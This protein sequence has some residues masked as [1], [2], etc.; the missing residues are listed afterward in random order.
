M[1]AI[2]G[3]ALLCGCTAL[4]PLPSV[5][6]VQ[7]PPV[8]PGMA[9]AWYYRA[10]LPYNGT[11]R[12]YVQMNGANVGIAELGGAFYR[13][14]APGPYY[15]TADTYGVDINQFPHATLVPGETAYFQVI[16]SRWW[17][18]GASKNWERPTFYIR[19]MPVAVGAAEVAHSEFYP[20]GG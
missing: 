11:A 8:P 1:A 12:P 19:Q 14:V 15:V 16:S 17:A 6:S 5:A 4:A 7:I 13:D 10:D 20:T 3:L 18:S 9:R 2:A